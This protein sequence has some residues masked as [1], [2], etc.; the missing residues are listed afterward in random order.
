[1]MGIIRRCG[2][3]RERRRG[4]NRGQGDRN[5]LGVYDSMR[6]DMCSSLAVFSKTI[7]ET[8]TLAVVKSCVRMTMGNISYSWNNFDQLLK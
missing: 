8:I 5:E 3:N 2:R 7:L 6:I 1:M 4:M